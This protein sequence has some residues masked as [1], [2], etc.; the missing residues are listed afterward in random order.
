M[1]CASKGDVQW[2]ESVRVSSSKLCLGCPAPADNTMQQGHARHTVCLGIKAA[3]Q[4]QQFSF[5]ECCEDF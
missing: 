1:S 2:I 4:H 5:S 3:S